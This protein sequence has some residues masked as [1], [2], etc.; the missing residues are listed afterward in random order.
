[1]SEDWK[2]VIH[3]EA[4]QNIGILHIPCDALAFNCLMSSVIE[5]DKEQYI[6]YEMICVDC[7]KTVPKEWVEKKKALVQVRHYFLTGEKLD[8]NT[9]WQVGDTMTWIETKPNGK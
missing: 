2:V 3:S 8:G 5:N 4:D 7:G 6:Y 1:M 9:P